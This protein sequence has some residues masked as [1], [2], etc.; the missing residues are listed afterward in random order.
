M[1]ITNSDIVYLL[2]GGTNNNNPLLSIGGSPSGTL[3]L[4]SINNLFDNVSNEEALVGANEYRCFY[5][6]NNTGPTNIQPDLPERILYRSRIYVTSQVSGGS[7]AIIGVT[8]INEIQTISISATPVGGNFSI[9]Y[10]GQIDQTINYDPD[11]T[12]FANNLQLAL[13]NYP[14]LEGIT[15]NG[16]N[17]GFIKFDISFGGKSGGR[18]HSLLEI[19]N[20]S[21]TGVLI[22]DINVNKAVEGAPINSVATNIGFVQNPPNNVTFGLPDENSPIEIGDLRGRDFIPIWIK[23]SVSAGTEA[24]ALDGITIRIE[25][26]LS[27]NE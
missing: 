21:L 17:P 22:S 23:R 15:V 8:Q 27:Q 12:I 19:T 6:Y 24:K 9:S 14:E 16:T 26:F 20:C 3:I 2:S 25:G 10:D 1:A 7:D 18:N 13:L 11:L 5:I 4:D